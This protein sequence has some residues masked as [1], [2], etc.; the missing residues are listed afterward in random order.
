MLSPQ[1]EPQG[2]DGRRLWPGPVG[3]TSRGMTW[4]TRGT[5]VWRNEEESQCPVGGR[6]RGRG[7][8]G[9]AGLGTRFGLGWG[10]GA[11]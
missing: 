8:R 9:G 4:S 6:N 2:A 1:G 5:L 11:P 10:S 7:A 3:G